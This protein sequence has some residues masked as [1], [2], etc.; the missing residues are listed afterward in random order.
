MPEKTESKPVSEE[1]LREE[2]NI[3]EE[4]HKEEKSFRDKDGTGYG[5]LM[6]TNVMPYNVNEDSETYVGLPAQTTKKTYI[7]QPQKKGMVDLNKITHTRVGDYINYYQNGV[8]D[9]GVIAKMSGSFITVFKEDGKF[10]DVH[11]NDTFFV[12]DILVN[13]TWND[14]SMEERTEELTKVKAYSPR[15]LSKTWEQLPQELRDVMK[16]RDPIGEPLGS[17]DPFKAVEGTQADNREKEEE[18]HNQM[19]RFLHHTSQENARGRTSYAKDQ[20]KFGNK[21]AEQNASLKSDQ[22]HEDEL[23]KIPLS[24]VANDDE[25]PASPLAW[26]LLNEKRTKYKKTPE[27]KQAMESIPKHLGTDTAEDAIN[28]GRAT[29]SRREAEKYKSDQEHGAYGTIGGSSNVAV[30]TDTPIDASED[31]EG[32]SHTDMNIANQFQHDSTKPETTK[33]KKKAGEFVYSDNPNTYKIPQTKTKGWGMKYGVK[34]IN[35]EEEE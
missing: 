19:R 3:E 9:S 20:A 6:S 30:S 2:S 26:N 10:Y 5:D 11:I 33:H 27:E 7:P 32:A 13:K 17:E 29:L 34:Y 8:E 16:K 15:Y 28:L 24:R 31:Y 21:Y 1:E 23:K 18:N 14:M 35:S 4:V 12:R 22:E 25:S